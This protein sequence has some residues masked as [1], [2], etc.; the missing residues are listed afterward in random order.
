MGCSA[1]WPAMGFQPVLERIDRGV[2]E[3]KGSAGVALGTVS[4]A[5]GG[6]RRS[7]VV[8]QW[9]PAWGLV[10]PRF[11]NKGVEVAAG[12]GPED[13]T[14][15][16]LCGWFPEV[17]GVGRCVWPEMAGGT[18][19]WGRPGWPGWVVRNGLPRLSV[20]SV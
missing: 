1:E 8:P 3:G 12:A 5:S 13:H 16:V 4:V 14:G 15:L 10:I 20:S 9:W 17:G 18:E 11:G 19:P 6:E 2:R 7:P